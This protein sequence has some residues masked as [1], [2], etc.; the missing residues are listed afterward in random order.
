MYLK[1]IQGS[2]NWAKVT[3]PD[4]SS[5]VLTN[6]FIKKVLHFFSIIFYNNGSPQQL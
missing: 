5:I 2:K 6:I 1:Y 3:V 4:L